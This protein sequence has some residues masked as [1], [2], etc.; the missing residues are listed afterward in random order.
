MA[1]QLWRFHGQ[2]LGLEKVVGYVKHQ[3]NHHAP[4]ELIPGWEETFEEVETPPTD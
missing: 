2:P 1:R 3:K 4:N